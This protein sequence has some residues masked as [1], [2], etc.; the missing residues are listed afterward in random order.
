MAIPYLYSVPLRVVIWSLCLQPYLGYI[1]FLSC[2][3]LLSMACL[4][5]EIIA[6]QKH[7]VNYQSKRRRIGDDCTFGNIGAAALVCSASFA[8]PSSNS[9]VKIL[10]PEGNWEFIQSSLWALTGFV[11]SSFCPSYSVSDGLSISLSSDPV[12]FKGTTLNSTHISNFYSKSLLVALHWAKPET[13]ILS[14]ATVE[15]QSHLV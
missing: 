8:L 6:V 7:I 11:I 1:D 5:D 15:Q 14:W 12:K 3:A 10:R 4:A 2:Y 13:Q 9:P